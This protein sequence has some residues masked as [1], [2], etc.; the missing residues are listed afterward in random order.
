MG[1]LI[2]SG[3]ITDPGNIC[4]RFDI[5]IKGGKIAAISPENT[6]KTDDHKVIRPEEKIVVPGLIDMHVHFREPGQEHKETIET[7][8][9]AAAQGGFF[10]VCAMP[11]TNPVNDNPGVTSH[12]L[13]KA[14]KACGVKL[15]PAGAITFGLSG[16]KLC[17]Y[18]KLKGAGIIAITDDGMPVTDSFVMRRALENAKKLDLPVISHSED[19][20][21]A[22]YGAMNEG[23]IAKKLGI[24]GIPN[25]AESIGV[26]RDIALCEFTGARL[27]IAHVSTREAAD[28]IRQAK[29]RGANLTCE[30]APHYFTL[31][32]EYVLKAGTNAK[33]NPPLRSKED[34]KAIRDALS[35]GTIDVIATDHAPHSKKEKSQKFEK[36]P[37]GI[38][39]LETSFPISLKLVEDGILDMAGLIG[40]MAVNPGKILGIKNRIKVGNPANLTILDIKSPYTIN[41]E[42]FKSLGKNT[43]FGGWQVK[44]KSVMVIADGKIIRDNFS[45]SK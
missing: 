8:C 16:K 7:G 32:D 10:A 1:I 14:K 17:D 2:K 4:G 37:N 38:I 35:D 41:P 5:L 30:T 11:N 43:P 21:L 24:A 26:M 18:E 33:M 34:V 39:G 27:H 19:L 42:N 13:E 31:T 20:A 12:M 45:G 44:G 28:A 23:K 15:F 36:A 9:M 6:I 3:N 22:R 40:K 29:K 25:A